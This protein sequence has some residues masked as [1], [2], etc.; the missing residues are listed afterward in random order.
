MTLF[1]NRVFSLAKLRW[2]NTGLGSALHP[3]TAVLTRGRRDAREAQKA[4]GQVRVKA[5]G[6]VGVMQLQAQGCQGRLLA[7]RSWKR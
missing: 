2:S 4:E 7:T 3:M 6:G 1:G 5:G